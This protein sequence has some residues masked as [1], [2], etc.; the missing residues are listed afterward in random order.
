MT[1]NNTMWI[2]NNWFR[3]KYDGICSDDVVVKTSHC[4]RHSTHCPPCAQVQLSSNTQHHGQPRMETSD[5]RAFRSL[6]VY[7]DM[8]HDS[9]VYYRWHRLVTYVSVCFPG[10]SLLIGSSVHIFI[11]QCCIIGRY[12]KQG[13]IEETHTLHKE[14]AFA[15]ILSV[16][17]P[18]N[19][20]QTLPIL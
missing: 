4:L 9:S 16:P 19:T 18:A 11:N 6:D 3:H 5:M 2:V 10:Q 20:S 14:R 7:G 1:R 12:S 17:H 8:I 15:W 13:S